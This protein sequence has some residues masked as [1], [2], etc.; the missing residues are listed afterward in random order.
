MVDH[1]QRYVLGQT[2]LF[3]KSLSS[4]LPFSHKQRFDRD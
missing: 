2:A 1:A 3:L 4:L